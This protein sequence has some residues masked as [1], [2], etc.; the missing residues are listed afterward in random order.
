[1]SNRVLIRLRCALAAIAVAPCALAQPM[2]YPPA[3]R[4]PV[5]DEYFGVKVPDPYRW[6]EDEQS[7]QSQEW[8][9]AQNAITFAHLDAIPARD[10]LVGRITELYNFERFGIPFEEG[11]KYFW[12][13]N[14]GLQNQSVLYVADSLQSEPRVLID[15]NTFSADGTV[16]LSGTSVSPD[17]RLIAYAVSDGGSDWN[18]WRVMDV[19]TGELLDDLVEHTKFTGI[20]WDRDSSGFYYSRYPLGE[21]GKP[22]DQKSLIVY[23]HAL[24]AA[25]DQDELVYQAEVPEHNAY[26]AVTEDGKFLMIYH[27][28]GYL[29]NAVYSKRL[30]DPEAEVT[31][32]FDKWDARY[33]F[34]GNVGET[35]LFSTTLEAPNTRVIAVGAPNPDRIRE[36]IPEQEQPVQGVSLVGRHLI[37]EYL[38][39][40]RSVVKVFDIAG[41]HLRN[42][43]LP[44]IGSAAGFGGH[45]DRTETFYSFTGFTSPGAIYRYDVATGA[46]ELFREPKVKIDLDQFETN[47]VFYESRDG[48][49][50]PMFLVHRKGLE[51]NGQ[52]P[53]LLYGY[54]GFNISL[55]PSFSVSRLAWIEMGGVYAVANLRGGGE[56]G[57]EWHLAGTKA[58][59]QNVFDDFI[60][61]AE[62]LIA[63]GYTSTPKLAIEGGSNGGLLVGACMTQ[64]PDLY[65]A[66]VPH[67]GVLDMLRYHLQSANAR[68]WSDDYGLSENEEDF[69][70][71]W[72]YSPYH[73]VRDGACYPPTLVVTAEGDD[74]VMPW[75]SYK[76]AAMLQHAHACDNPVLI[77]VETRAGHG[78]GK[79][80]SMAIK[81][82]ADVY[83]FLVK[84]LGMD[85]E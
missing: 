56:Y 41:R 64:R 22:D 7:E 5:V 37:V 23:H 42:V 35:M 1:M 19:G 58:S 60:A 16:A 36:V 44:G 69:R 77:R 15:P 68:Q 81:E 39:D 2:E 40:A 50:V 63:E 28:H 57:E 10:R 54:G 72:A 66:C 3:E 26:A 34:L 49:K 51:L 11:G 82:T 21:D 74:R 65:G 14:D 55:T 85:V 75:H 6:L 61:A 47:Q 30:D 27:S 67:V 9:R 25:Q 38:E 59:K 4:Q 46:S 24:G 31:P 43:D 33:D 70:A 17:G 8:I 32:V 76:F 48:T 80:L 12:S 18:T 73:N 20:S 71:Q 78:G 29:A 53:T 62:W 13:R 52:N 83:A 84:H 79:P 45:A